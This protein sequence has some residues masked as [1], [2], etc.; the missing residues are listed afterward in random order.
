[1]K[2]I[3][4]KNQPNLCDLKYTVNG[5]VT[6]THKDVK[7]DI[8]TKEAF[9]I[10]SPTVFEANIS[11]SSYIKLSSLLISNRVGFSMKFLP[12]GYLKGQREDLYCLILDLGHIQ[13]TPVVTVTHFGNSYGDI[14]IDDLNVELS[15][16]GGT[17]GDRTDNFCMIGKNRIKAL[18]LLIKYLAS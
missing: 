15:H 1:V 2:N 17:L 18:S 7:K 4:I 3:N 9:A 10:K 11:V 16:C 12:K 13:N 8:D 5:G 6:I 14:L